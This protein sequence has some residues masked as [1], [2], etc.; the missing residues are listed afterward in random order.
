LFEELQ[1]SANTPTN[2][3]EANLMGANISKNPAEGHFAK[4]PT[5][6]HFEEDAG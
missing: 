2:T 6:G 3:T 1:P 4:N 5:E